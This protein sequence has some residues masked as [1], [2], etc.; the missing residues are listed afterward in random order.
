ML[1]QNKLVGNKGMFYVGSDGAIAA[2]LVY[3]IPSAGKMVIEHTEVDESLIGKNVGKLLV[4]TAVNYART[5]NIKIV[6]LC[7]FAKSLFDKNP[8]WQDVLMKS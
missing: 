8:E 4:E 3:N 1:I 2:E 5:H 7:V 6:T